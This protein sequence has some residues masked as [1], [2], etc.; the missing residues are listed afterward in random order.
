MPLFICGKCM[1]A[2]QPR[3]HCYRNPVYKNAVDWERVLAR[4]G[5]RISMWAY[6]QGNSSFKSSICE[7]LKTPV[8]VYETP[9]TT[10]PGV[11]RPG[12]AHCRAQASSLSSP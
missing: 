10:L 11:R 7:L 2:A 3:G 8:T 12:S 1:P 9:P 4:S 6:F 5:L